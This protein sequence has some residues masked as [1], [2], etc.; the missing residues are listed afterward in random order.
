MSRGFG[1]FSRRVG[2][3]TSLSASA[4]V[5]RS[6][7]ARPGSPAKVV[8]VAPKGGVGKTTLT[9]ALLVSAR[10]A[11][12]KVLGINMDGQRSL[13]K[14][15]IRR[16]NQRKTSETADI[17]Q[18]PVEYVMVHDYRAL[19]GYEQYDLLFI[20]TPPGHG[21]AHNSIRAV[22]EMA[23]LV[24]IPTS[25]SP[26]DLDQVVP[27]AREITSRRSFFVLNRVNRRAKSFQR[28]KHVLVKHGH[29]CPVDIPAFEAIPSQFML[30]LA[31][32]DFED[33]GSE[34]FEALWDF[35]RNELGL[36]ADSTGPERVSI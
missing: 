7:K 17:V 3:E 21:D 27:F 10:R 22:C 6:V 8:V 19:R 5:A 18:I 34:S 28:A 33:A 15:G 29:L 26:M 25:T 1:P 9:M 23:D 32:T 31:S 12:L 16:Q 36:P 35:V 20:D 14:W 4:F 11:G 13:D 24:L 2:R 30:G